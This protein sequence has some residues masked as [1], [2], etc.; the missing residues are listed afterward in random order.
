VLKFIFRLAGTAKTLLAKKILFLNLSMLLLHCLGIVHLVCHLKPTERLGVS[1]VSLI[2]YNFQPIKSRLNYVS[3][4]DFSIMVRNF[5]AIF[6]IA[7]R[8]FSVFFTIEFLPIIF[9]PTHP[10]FN[11][12]NNDSILTHILHYNRQISIYSAY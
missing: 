11:I 9:S 4:D 10:P 1:M 7:F 6:C 12:N 8:N 2:S 3:F 5:Y